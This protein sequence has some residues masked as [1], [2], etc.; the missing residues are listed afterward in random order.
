MV[1][2]TN[3]ASQMPYLAPSWQI[4]PP[5]G[6]E[7]RVMY[8]EYSNCHRRRAIN[9]MIKT[10]GPA[11][12]EVLIGFEDFHVYFD[13]PSGILFYPVHDHFEEN[14]N[15]TL[16]GFVTITFN[17]L[18]TFWNILPGNIR[19]IVAIIETSTGQKTSFRVDGKFVSASFCAF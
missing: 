2:E 6:N 1:D 3:N 5:I 11:M 9:T 13:Q 12:S 16:V 8:N 15:R 14:K 17:W 10:G 4:Y 7:G 19:G 18:G